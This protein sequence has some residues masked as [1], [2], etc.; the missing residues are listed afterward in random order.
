[1]GREEA[2]QG[3]RGEKKTKGMR[4]LHVICELLTT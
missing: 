3:E 1:M 4:A 2:I